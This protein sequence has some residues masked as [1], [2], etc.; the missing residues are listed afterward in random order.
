M[1][2]P[3]IEK[4]NFEGGGGDNEALN[5]ENM[6][7]ED[8]LSDI[9]TPFDHVADDCGAGAAICGIT[10]DLSL[11][12]SCATSWSCLSYILIVWANRIIPAK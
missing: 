12:L 7:Y 5:R 2:Y 8:E 6:V 10:M 4:N 1:K 11:V 3:K 9:Y